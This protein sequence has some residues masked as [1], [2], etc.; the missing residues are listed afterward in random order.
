MC[1]SNISSHFCFLGS[2]FSLEQCT[3]CLFVSLYVPRLLQNPRDFPSSFGA[4]G[5]PW[6]NQRTFGGFV[7]SIES[8]CT[9]TRLYFSQDYFYARCGIPV[10]TQT[11]HEGGGIKKKKEVKKKK[12]RNDG[13]KI[14]RNK[15]KK[16]ERQLKSVLWFGV[17][18][19]GRRTNAKSISIVLPNRRLFSA[20]CHVFAD[21]KRVNEKKREK[22]GGGREKKERGTTK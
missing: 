19:R 15:I 9:V 16:K 20:G 3:W 1:M 22:S 12:K 5:F 17:H 21:A 2:Q 13:R 11:K 4:T 7:T 6:K 18:Q 8:T 14:E 10:F